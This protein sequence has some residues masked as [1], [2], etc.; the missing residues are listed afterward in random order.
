MDDIKQASLFQDFMHTSF[1]W[2]LI[3]SNMSFMMLNFLSL[4]NF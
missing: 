4:I 1:F 2:S 3:K